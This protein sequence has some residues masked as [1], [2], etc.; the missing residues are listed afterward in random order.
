[1]LLL[2][3]IV[4]E[5]LTLVV[6]RQHYYDKSWMRYYFIMIL[7]AALSI[8]LWILWFETSTYRGIFDEPHHQWVIQNLN[9]M[10]CAVVIPRILIIVFH[11]SGILSRRRIG[12]HSRKLT[13]SGLILASIIFLIIANGTLIGRFNIKTENTQITVKG[14][15]KDLEGLKI[16]H[17]SDLH[18]ISYYHH[19]KNLEQVMDEINSINPDLI[20]NTGDFINVGWRE[21]RRFDTILSKAKSRYG[22]F[23][24]MG[25]HDF[26][27]YNPF[28]TEADKKNNVLLMNKFIELSGY[29][30]LNDEYTIVNIGDSKL[31]L[32]GVT[33]RGSFPDIIHS[34][35]KK[36]F[37]DDPGTDLRILLAHDPNQWDKEVAGKT[38]IDLTLSGHTHGM[39][40]GITTKKLRWS[41]A[42]FFYQ[43]WSGLYKDGEQYLFVNQGLGALG[44]PVRIWM[45]P[46]ISVITLH[47]E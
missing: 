19:Q 13:N 33:T 23:A 41:P 2:I 1:M 18:L 43:H 44:I 9:G 5:I 10:I 7:N 15:P 32:I 25:N 16:V 17:I 20:L 11:F 29:K 12:G 46:E 24:V 27:T 4:T 22:N 26:G 30:L 28:F 40:I 21:F 45:P 6:I 3:L 37:K 8:W 35:V 42:R 47:A 38:E 34:S 36:A 39:Q 31:A 14:L